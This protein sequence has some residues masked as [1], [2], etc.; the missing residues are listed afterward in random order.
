MSYVLPGKLQPDNLQGRF[1]R[2]RQLMGGNHHDLLTQILESEKKL[3]VKSILGLHSARYGP[4]TF[5]VVN[6]AEAGQLCKSTKKN[7][8]DIE[9]DDHEFV[10]LF[11]APYEIFIDDQRIL[12][13]PSLT[14]ICEYAS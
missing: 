9:I 10:E 5:S 3:G 2:Y 7:W 12:S 4:I 14:Y 1:S 13:E 6:L 11:K 8:D